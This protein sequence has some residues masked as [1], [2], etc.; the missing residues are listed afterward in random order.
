[1]SLFNELKRRNVFRIGAAYVVGAWLLIQ[2]TETIFPLF[3]F[4]DTPARLVVIV[5]AIGFIP[6]LILS[7]VFEFTPEGLKKDADVDFEESITQSTGRKLDRII[8]VALALA[9][10]YFAFD[11][12][13]LDPVE[14]EQI[15]E[16]ARQEGLTA[17]LSKSYGN[18]S[19]AVLPFEN[20]SNREE[21]Q[22]FTDGIHDDLLT[23]IAKIGSMKVISRTS[24]M[25][26]RDTIKKI[27]QIAKELGVANI[28]EGGIQRSGN[29]VRIN[30]Q[31][32]DAATDDHLWAEIYDRELTAENLFAVQSEITR[33][34]ADALRA[35]LSTDEQRRIDAIPTDN[36]QAYEAYMRGRQLM[37]T[38]NTAKL[39]RAT[40]E[41]SKATEIDPMFA[42]AWVG[43]A[44]SHLLLSGRR[45]FR[46]KDLLPI[47]EDAVKNALAIDNDL[48][49]AYASLGLMHSDHGRNDEAE[50]AFQKAI[51]LSPN[52]ATAY[53]W[54]AN[55][56]SADPLR[57]QERTDL[58]Q[59]AAKL[60]PRSAIIAHNLGEGYRNRG[61]YT[62][63]ENQYKKVIEVHPD[64]EM[65]YAF[66]PLLY[67]FDMGQFDKALA[68]LNKASALYPES[69]FYN[70]LKVIIY[71]NLGDLEAAQENR[72]KLT[73]SGAE[74]WRLG[75]MDVRISFGKENPADTL[76]LINRL[77]PKMQ[78]RTSIVPR[79]I[80]ASMAL[81]LGDIQLSREIYLSVEPRWLEPD[82]WPALM[83]GERLIQ[84]GCIVAWL[85]MNTGDQELGTALLQQTT[86]YIEDTLPLMT[87]HPD[88]LFPETCYLTAGDTE[89]A[90]LSIETALAHNHLS[91]W[92]IFHRMPMYDLIRHEP[93]Y[94]AALAERERRISVQRENIEKMA[95]D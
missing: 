12:F 50:T 95:A 72:D 92:Y 87:E 32:I 82:Q 75:F 48:G 70:V 45:D 34:I 41:F 86:A 1:M 43:V 46:D 65:T 11:K 37:A 88:Q 24:V 83:G 9:L 91:D 51:E 66:L 63:A 54:Y 33:I 76:E 30:V 25:E 22:F 39:K 79:R 84:T 28:L 55:A 81:T 69:H 3:G 21:D 52:Y 58:I 78:H 94:Q 89:K 31:L 85:F 64:F 23:T 77:L 15:A 16:S 27:P 56:I 29:H 68:L 18:R 57:F 49:E 71:M 36:L 59:K 73:G 17:A 61:H 44:D 74:E 10:G 53:K 19:I 40:E 62:L 13:V 8:L 80:L 14:D 35:E 6:S 67:L 60:D 5:L 42:L 93:R 90:L 4:G 7:W 38:R 2:V 20:R 26:Y 47:I